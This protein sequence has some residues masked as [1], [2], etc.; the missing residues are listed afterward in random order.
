[1]KKIEKNENNENNENVDL[2]GILSLVSSFSRYKDISVRDRDDEICFLR[3]VYMKLCKEYTR[4]NLEEI[5]LVCGERNHTTVINGL[6]QFDLLYND[7]KFE[8][9][10]KVYLSVS[11]ILGERL[12]NQKKEIDYKEIFFEYVKHHEEQME[13]L[14]KKVNFLEKILKSYN[15]EPLIR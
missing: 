3:Y 11:K 2:K 9:A 8:K 7:Q 1:M 6:K 13:K 4:S 12:S 15:Q 10:K 5:G 14:Q